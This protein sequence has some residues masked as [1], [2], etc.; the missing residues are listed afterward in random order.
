M[1]KI[2]VIP[3]TKNDISRLIDKCSI[4]LGLEGYSVNTLNITFKELEYLLEKSNDVFVSINKNFSNKEID[5][6]ENIL[7]KLS[8]INVKGV[9][10]CDVAVLNIVNRLNLNVNLIW[11]AEHLTTNYFTVNYWC[12]HNVDGAFLSNEITINEILDIRKNT[13]C[14][15]FVQLFGY[16]PMY[17][18]KRHAIDNYFKHF[19]IDN[20]V[21]SDSYHL[22]KEDKKY[23]IIDNMD[24]TFIYSGFILDG[25]RESLILKN[26]DYIIL[27]SYCIDIDNI[28]E[29]VDSFNGVNDENID[30]LEDKLSKMF[31]NLDKGF[32]H[33][34]TIYRVKKYDK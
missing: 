19:N 10:Y 17:V 32:L 27:N 26:I 28:L 3:N 14:M 7:I 5:L 25:L 6:L 30:I 16:I 12:K 18:S 8:N 11:S 24:G 21:A 13:D 4:L 15:L 34:E 29:V 23:S 1:S 2:M 22:Y 20:K 9:F 33:E 31:S